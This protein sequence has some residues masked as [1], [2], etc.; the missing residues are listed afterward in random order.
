MTELDLAMMSL[1][2][3]INSLPYTLDA[4]QVDVICQI[5]FTHP[6]MRELLCQLCEERP[7]LLYPLS[8]AIKDGVINSKQ[9]LF[10]WAGLAGLIT[11]DK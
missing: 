5:F 3:V 6:G 8:I 2:R 1:K 10:N 11:V 7:E 4:E 9:D